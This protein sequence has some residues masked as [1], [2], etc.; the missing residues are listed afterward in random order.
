M[1]D[2]ACDSRGRFWAGTMQL[3]FEPDAGSLYGLDR[4]G[5]VHTMLR[6][7]TISSGIAWSLDDTRMYFADTP[8]REIEVFDYDAES[9]AIE[10]RRT[11]AAIEPGGGDP[12][13]LI[14]DS[15]RESKAVLCG[16]P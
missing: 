11:F 2:G 9:G 13:G 16:G 1:N 3:E 8:K 7:V 5:T 15:E 6:E 4:D 14:V 10:N 12:D